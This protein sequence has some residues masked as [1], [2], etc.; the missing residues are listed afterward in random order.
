MA[1]DCVGTI[2]VDVLKTC[3]VTNNDSL[4]SLTLTKIV[5]N[6]NGGTATA[7][8]FTLSASGPTPLSGAG[9][10]VSSDLTFDAGTYTLS[11]SG[12]AGYTA[13]AWSCKGGTQSGNQITVALGESAAC[14]I[15]NDDAIATPAGSTVQRAILHDTLNVTGIRAGGSPALTATFRLYSDAACSVQVGVAETV[16][17]T[18]VAPAGVATTVNGVQVSQNGAYRWRVSF[19]GNSFNEPFVTA[20]GSEISTIT[21]VQ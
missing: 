12:P 11:E 4:P 19:S 15:T 6:N 17:V 21:F 5:V 8:S 1:G 14:S 7:S 18:G 3:T 16:S 13:S 9:P 10:T 20:C 2:E